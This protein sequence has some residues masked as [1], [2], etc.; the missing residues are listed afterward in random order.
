M[1]FLPSLALACLA[2]SIIANNAPSKQRVAYH[3]CDGM[4]ISWSTPKHISNP[5]VMYGTSE[6][7]LC[8]SAESR[9][10][11]TYPT[12]SQY[13]NHVILSGLQPDTTYYYQVGHGEKVEKRDS[14][15]IPVMSF[16]TC[17]QAGDM[18]P[19]VAAVVVDLG[20]M[21]PLGLSTKVGVGA[22][23]PLKPGEVN[24]I[25]RLKYQ[26]DDYEFVAHPGDIAYADYW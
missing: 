23:N 25:Q 15:K 12:A 19:Y 21:G 3:G 16:K 10:S 13:S 22:A 26:L 18:T 4:S 17:K 20:T 8:N 6:N 1:V 9:I 11:T 24:T 7:D 2:T 14:A 5:R